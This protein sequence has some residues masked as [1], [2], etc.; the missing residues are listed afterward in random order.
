[1]LNGAVLADVMEP[2][3]PRINAP[4][5]SAQHMAQNVDQQ[6]SDVSFC[7]THWPNTPNPHPLVGNR[8]DS[9]RSTMNQTKVALHVR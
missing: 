8:S 9:C 4:T 6:M 3:N 7:A 2:S 5:Q 1:M